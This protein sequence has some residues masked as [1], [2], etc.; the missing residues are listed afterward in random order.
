[1]GAGRDSVYGRA[2]VKRDNGREGETGSV[3]KVGGD[4]REQVV[5]GGWLEG[6]RVEG[7][8]GRGKGG[9]VDGGRVEGRRGEGRVEGR[10]GRRKGGTEKLKRR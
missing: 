3:N 5:E 2:G 9:R 6:G 10:R 7:R 1:M 4:D 8:R